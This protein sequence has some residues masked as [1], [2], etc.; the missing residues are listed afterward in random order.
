[1]RLMQLALVLVV[2][3]AGL[4]VWMAQADAVHLLLSGA[5]GVSS[6][7][8]FGAVAFVVSRLQAHLVAPGLLAFGV[9]WWLTRARCRLVVTTAPD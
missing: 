7:L 8:V 6:P 4:W 2:L 5:A 3:H 1:M 9:V